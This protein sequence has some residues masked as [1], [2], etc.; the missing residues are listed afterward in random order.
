[1]KRFSQWNGW[2]TVLLTIAVSAIGGLASGRSKKDERA[3]YDKKLQQAPWAPPG[4]LFGPAWSINNYFLIR[5]LQRLLA[6]EHEQ[7]R[8]NLIG[9]QAGI[10]A[11]FFTFGYVYFRKKSPVLAATWTISDAAL[12]AISFFSSLKSDRKLAYHYLP[13]LGWTAFASTVAGYQAL[14]N[15]DPVL[16]SRAL[17]N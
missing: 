10:W 15:D 6:S 9:M 17:L 11:I 2:Q 3:L 14:H 4:W 13:L 5:A 1:M 12:A 16:H 7:N 8:K